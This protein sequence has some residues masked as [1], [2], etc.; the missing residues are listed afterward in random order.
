MLTRLCKAGS[1]G[2]GQNAS[3]KRG[4]PR[5]H[6]ARMETDVKDKGQR[7]IA[8][9]SKRAGFADVLTL[10]GI[11]E[12]VRSQPLV[13]FAGAGVLGAALGGVFFPRLGRLAFLAAAGYVG[14]HLLQRQRALDVDEVVGAR[15]HRHDR[16]AI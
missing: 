9:E 13:A 8:F 14:N 15:S 12:L 7:V 4:M 5:A 3:Q 16:S 11:Q 1:C 6:P 10:D 2:D